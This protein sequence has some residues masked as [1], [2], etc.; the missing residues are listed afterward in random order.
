MAERDADPGDQL[1]VA[2]PVEALVAAALRDGRA[3]AEPAGVGVEHLRAG[4]VVPQRDDH[5]GDQLLPVLRRTLQQAVVADVVEGL[6]EGLVHGGPV[7][8]VRR[9][10]VLPRV[11]VGVGVGQLEGAVVR[12]VELALGIPGRAV[13]E[14]LGRLQADGPFL[15]AGGGLVAVALDQWRE[16]LAKRLDDL[17]LQLVLHVTDLLSCVVGHR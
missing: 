2:D 17:G 3:V 5:L 12:V 8:D 6:A 4:L 14:V 15:V 1:R 9:V 10:V 7:G 13:V 16:S 11:G